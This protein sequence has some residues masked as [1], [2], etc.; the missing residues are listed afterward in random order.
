MRFDRLAGETVTAGC[1]AGASRGCVGQA[2]RQPAVP[3][4]K[5]ARLKTCPER[6]R[7]GGFPGRLVLE[8]GAAQSA[9]AAVSPARAP[10]LPGA[11]V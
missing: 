10:S 8:G 6:K 4:V 7:P 1:A 3:N 2:G 9:R 11:T 5:T